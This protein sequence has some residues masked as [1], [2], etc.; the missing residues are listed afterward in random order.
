M[1]AR[2]GD[3]TLIGREREKQVLDD[4]LASVRQ[5]S[6]RVL[7]LR[8]EP[9]SGRTAL[10]DRLSATAGGLDVLRLTGTET[11]TDLP[12]AAVQRALLPRASRIADLPAPQADALRTA[13]GTS[14]GPAPD[15]FLVSLAVLSL[16]AALSD[17][18]PVLVLA[19]DA[20][21][22]DRESLDLLAFVGRRLRAER[23]ALVLS[24]RA[25]TPGAAAVSDLPT[26]DLAG[27][28]RDAALSLLRSRVGTALDPQVADSI[29]AATGGNPL[30]LL[31][32]SGELSAAQLAGG[33]VLS[34]PLPVGSHLE[35]HYQ[36]HTRAYARPTQRWLLLAAT[37]P[38]GDTAYV[39]A[40]AEALG[41]PDD[42]S[43]APERDRLVTVESH[44]AF[45]HPLVRSAVY[46]G[47]TG[48]ERRAAHA[49]LAAVT[50]RPADVDQRAWHLSAAALGPDEGVAA[51]L[52]QG[53]ERARARGGYAA[54]AAF[55]ARAVELTAPGPRRDGRA[56]SAAEAASLAGSPVRAL[57]L[58][59]GVDE[60]SLAPAVLAR[61]LTAR[62]VARK[63]SGAPHA[64]AESPGL[65]LRAAR[66]LRATDPAAAQD[67]LLT[68]FGEILGA[69]RA[70]GDDTLADLAREAR[71]QE[72]D[73]TDD[74][75]LDR[76]SDMASTL[77][78]A[79]AALAT[80][81]DARCVPALRAA[82][83]AMRAPGA[84]SSETFQRH[85]LL[86]VAVTT[87]LWDD[88][89]RDELVRQA[90]AQTRAAGAI[91]ALDSALWVLA[92]CET[93]MGQLGAADHL[94][95][96]VHELR[97]AVGLSPE[98]ARI[99][100]NV[101]LLAWHGPD[102]PALRERIDQAQG[103]AD[104]L[105][106][107]GAASLARTA[108]MLLD[109]AAGDHAAAFDA[110]SAIAREGFL[111]VGLRVLPDLVESARR[112]GHDD[113]ARAALARLADVTLASGAPWGLGVLARSRAL[114][115][116]DGEADAHFR[117]AVGHLSRTRAV[118]DL[119]RTHLLHGEWLRRRRRRREATVAL[120][121]ALDL[122]E[123]MGAEPFAARARRELAAVTGRAQ[124]P[125]DRPTTGLTA[126]EQ[127]VAELAAT[128]AT[129]AEIAA[130]L[131]ISP[132]TVHYH[133]RKA[134][135][136]LGVSSR[137]QLAHA[138]RPPDAGATVRR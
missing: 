128:G 45:R 31:D 4:L 58:L 87:A 124:V 53:A 78:G 62:A 65:F 47:A 122:F 14:S 69:E 24:V 85:G 56:V 21:W 26:V 59:D 43:D 49:A 138:L 40:A 25:G 51:A 100:A 70:A 32:L 55:L 136:K 95:A 99:F 36:R 115:A 131:F 109:L 5:G 90:A 10:L 71:A 61:C 33:A 98:Q 68:A 20:Q 111:Q 42:A 101:E 13:L 66:T 46:R 94:L 120:G 23:V 108:R 79:L 118:A 63:Y 117:D 96:E 77:L 130:H 119:A 83:E 60:N 80:T 39:R 135:R 2:P 22:L 97:E 113:A 112:S 92:L 127:S 73:S 27:L 17:D 133:L 15:R 123:R 82:V 137:R 11:E 12:F 88:A 9:G 8:G 116:E 134:F 48:S 93:V 44:V 75:T 1:S 67:A 91:P 103:A 132:H 114:L 19:D 30:A 104:H 102:F 28:P 64:A 16:L 81:P 72:V 89:A 129:N 29:V 7:V 18:A 41:L 86:A 107:G 57:A 37:E 35:D 110:A 121:A 76:P 50:N 84:A 106:L 74:T 105:G 3:V 6:S 126:Q 54:R 52:E 38:G 34:A 125:L